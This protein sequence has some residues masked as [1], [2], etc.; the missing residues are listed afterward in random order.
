MDEHTCETCDHADKTIDQYPCN[1]C[2]DHSEWQ[3]VD[4]DDE[5]DDE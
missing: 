4:D 2:R 1:R 3:I 5:G